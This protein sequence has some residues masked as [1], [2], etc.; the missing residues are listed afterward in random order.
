MHVLKKKVFEKIDS[1][2][3]SFIHSIVGEFMFAQYKSDILKS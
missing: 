1:F 3:A 2:N